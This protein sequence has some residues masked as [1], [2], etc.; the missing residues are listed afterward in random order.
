MGRRASLILAL[1]LTACRGTEPTRVDAIVVGAGPAGLAAAWELEQAGQRVVLV[2][3]H[4]AVGG[5]AR[6]GMGMSLMAGTSTQEAQGV[7]DSPVRLLEDWESMTG[8]PADA[9]EQGFVLAAPT[10]VHDWL[11]ELGVRWDRLHPEV[12]TNTLRDHEP[13]GGSTSI[14]LALGSAL[15]LEPRLGSWVTRLEPA[16]AGGWQVW[17]DGER[18]PAYAATQVILATGSLYGNEQRASEHDATSACSMD[19]LVD[20]KDGAVPPQADTLSMLAAL[21]P[22]TSNM[23]ALGLYPHVLAVDD[24][25]YI[26]AHGAAVVDATGARIL[27]THELNSIHAGRRVADQPECIAWAVFGQNSMPQVLQQLTADRRDALLAQG[28]VLHTAEGA[29]DLAAV[30]G[31]DPKILAATLAN[32][33]VYRPQ[34]GPIQRGQRPPFWAARLGLVAGKSFGGLQTDLEGRLLDQDGQP[35]PGLFAAGELAGMGGGG[36]GAPWGFDGSLSAVIHSGRVA[37]SHAAQD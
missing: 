17:L 20:G 8:A 29:A 5:R 26:D 32:A 15:A 22:A 7:Q 18:Q 6:W 19:A 30:L 9:W 21:S 13:R 34:P 4:D 24:H 23:G 35:V 33:P 10:Q 37:G 16:K 27:E 12:V 36:V 11:A 3:G 31:M 1:M 25:P 28:Q 14:V 2:D